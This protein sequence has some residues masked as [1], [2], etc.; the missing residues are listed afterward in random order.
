MLGVTAAA[1]LKSWKDVEN[2]KVTILLPAGW[3]LRL[4][5]LKVFCVQAAVWGLVILNSPGG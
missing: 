5:A 3:R 1:L 4:L 2:C